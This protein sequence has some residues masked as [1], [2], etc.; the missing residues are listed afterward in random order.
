MQILNAWFTHKTDTKSSGTLVVFVWCLK[1]VKD[2]ILEFSL[3]G[4]FFSEKKQLLG[5]Y[6]IILVSFPLGGYVDEVVDSRANY[7]EYRY[8]VHFFWYHTFEVMRS[9]T[10]EGV[11]YSLKHS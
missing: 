11:L 4:S 3:S 1:Q 6:A 10:V 9:V 8:D 5:Y 7:Q 2:L